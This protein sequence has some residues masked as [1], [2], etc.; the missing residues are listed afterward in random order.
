MTKRYSEIRGLHERL[1]KA[2]TL[3]G[4][5]KLPDFPSWFRIKAGYTSTSSPV[6]KTVDY[7]NKEQISKRMDELEKYLNE[8]SSN[9]VALSTKYFVDFIGLDMKVPI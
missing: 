2:N 3:L 4:G 5:L 1:E 9:A 7:M 6:L 8:L